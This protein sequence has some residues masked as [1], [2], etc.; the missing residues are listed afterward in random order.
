MTCRRLPPNTSAGRTGSRG[1]FVE[2]AL[3]QDEPHRVQDMPFFSAK[4]RENTPFLM[5]LYSTE[6]RSSRIA[7][8]GDL[9]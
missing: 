9:I 8:L 2:P 4:G 6:L 7:S 3:H 5:T 1:N